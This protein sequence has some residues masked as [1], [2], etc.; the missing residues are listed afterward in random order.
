MKTNALS[1]ANY[2]IERSH[3]D[4]KDITPLKLMKLVYIAYGFGLAVLDRSIIDYRFDAVEAWRLGPV[5]PSVYHSF[6]IYGKGDVKDLTTMLVGDDTDFA[7]VTPKI[8]E[9]DTEAV[10]TCE[11]VWKRYGSYDGSKLVKILHGKGTPW[12][13]VYQEGRNNPIPERLTRLYYKELVS[14][15]IAYAHEEA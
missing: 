9:K 14:R 12:G 8:D 2:F 4:G 5:I 6:K 15:M 7:V 11:F 1:V 3:K 13:Q 10:S